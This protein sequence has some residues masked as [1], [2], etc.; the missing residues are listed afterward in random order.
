MECS[1]CAGPLSNTGPDIKV[2]A[3]GW[4]VIKSQ[5][6]AS[7]EKKWQCGLIGMHES[8]HS[9]SACSQE[10]GRTIALLARNWK[11]K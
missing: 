5:S 7:D 10:K 2:S 4:N 1:E 11:L 3:L 8:L 9:A 6:H